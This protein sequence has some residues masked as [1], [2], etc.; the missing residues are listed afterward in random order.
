M[1]VAQGGGKSTFES[2]DIITTSVDTAESSLNVSKEACTASS[3]C[4][5]HAGGVTC[6]DED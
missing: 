2:R 5:N 1:K 6:Q 3:R 4:V